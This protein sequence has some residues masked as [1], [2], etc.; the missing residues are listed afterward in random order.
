MPVG[1][2]VGPI[3]ADDDAAEIGHPGQRLDDAVQGRTLQ[4]RIQARQNQRDGMAL[5]MAGQF[6]LQI[7]GGPAAQVG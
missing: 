4:F 6:P 7:A 2:F 1:G 3:Q 5:G